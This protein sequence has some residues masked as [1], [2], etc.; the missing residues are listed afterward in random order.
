[1]SDWK[2]DTDSSELVPLLYEELHRQAKHLMRGERSNHTLQPTALVHEAWMRISKEDADMDRDGFFAVAAR[3]MRRVLIDH[4]RGRGRVKRGSGQVLVCLD[5]AVAAFEERTLDVLAI[6]EA[7]V[8]LES[9][10]P[11]L[12]RL[13]ELRFF[14]GL[15]IAETAVALGVS[16]PTVERSWRVARSWLLA[17]LD[18]S[19]GGS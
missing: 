13:V 1:M 17:E 16:T 5:E 3:C 6:D 2:G 9:F 19:A 14:S 7:L 4:A 8:K 10:D 11:E 15:T 18:E 12:A